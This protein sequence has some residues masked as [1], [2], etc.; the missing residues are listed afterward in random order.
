MREIT[1]VPLLWRGRSGMNCDRR[2]FAAGLAGL[3]FCTAVASASWPQ[4]PEKL[5]LRLGVANKSHLYYLP[6][7]LAERRGHF[8]D[9]GL[10]IAIVDFEGGGESLD[11]LMGGSVDVVTG[12]YEHTLRMQAKGQDVRALIELGRFPGIVLAVRKGRPY[13]SPADLK[14]MKIGVTAPGSSSSFFVLYLMA[15]AGLKATDA[16]FVGVG[17][18]PAAVDAMKSGDLD[19][20]SNYDPVITKLQQND[21][22]RI[23]VDTRFPRVN[24]EIFGGT[25][26][27]AVLYAKQDF[28][29]ANPDTT[30]ALVNAFYKTL[31]WIATATTDEIVSSVPQDYFLGDR[32]IYVKA[33]RSNLL[34]YSKTGV[35]TPQG[36][37]S[38]L[39]MLAAFDPDLIGAKFDLQKTFDDRFIKRATIL[40]DDPNNATLENDDRRPE[41]ELRATQ[42]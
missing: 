10:D 22:I 37:K 6:L 15:K 21:A 25:N 14:G 20:I 36:M 12:A 17:G 16:S 13:K 8:K 9:Y 30:Q 7:T 29:A 32:D 35:I 28:I 3:A 24:Y 11:A 40:F 42:D 33:L 26:P 31:K 38:A 41:I 18:G 27:A 34:V 2:T 4:Q 23:V 19:A 39:N 1:P 5:S